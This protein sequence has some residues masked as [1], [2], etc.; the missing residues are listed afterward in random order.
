MIDPFTT[1][2]AE[3]FGILADVQL[4]KGVANMAFGILMPI[5]V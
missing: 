3:L 1:F 2:I 4:T 5:E